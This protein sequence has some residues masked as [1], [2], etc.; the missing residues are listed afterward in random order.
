MN[1][2]EISPYMTSKSSSEI[3]DV[4]GPEAALWAELAGWPADLVLCVR[5]GK[6]TLYQATKTIDYDLWQSKR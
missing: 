2:K 6:Y 3:R 5:E 1:E 4:T